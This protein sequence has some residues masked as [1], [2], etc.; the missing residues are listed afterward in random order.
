MCLSNV[1]SA[2]DPAIVY[3]LDMRL[4]HLCHLCLTWQSKIAQI[5]CPEALPT[6]WG[7]IEAQLQQAAIYKV[8]ANWDM[9]PKP[10]QLLNH[11]GSEDDFGTDSNQPADELVGDLLDCV[12]A[13]D[14]HDAYCN[15][16]DLSWYLDCAHLILNSE[17]TSSPCKHHREWSPC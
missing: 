8:T 6:C 3:Q 9:A 2:N 4:D 7:P 17:S 12:E 1:F 16:T 14:L 10:T 13:A 15:E 11:G 5:P